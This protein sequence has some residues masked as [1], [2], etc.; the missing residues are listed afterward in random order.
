MKIN[1][2]KTNIEKDKNFLRNGEDEKKTTI[3]KKYIIKKHDISAFMTNNSSRI[4]NI[5]NIKSNNSMI[6]FDR[7][8]KKIVKKKDRNVF[9]L[10]FENAK[11]YNFEN[12]EFAKLG[13]E[14]NLIGKGA[15]SE[16]FLAKNKINEKYYAIKK[17]KF[18]L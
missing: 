10:E 12:F 3:I 7:N 5:Q 13:D 18:R 8:L 15:Y 1:N 16:V 6:D 2:Y 14:L 9:L 11:M 17:V 4:L